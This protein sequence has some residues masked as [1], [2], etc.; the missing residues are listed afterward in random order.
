MLLAYPLDKHYETNL[1]S[2]NADLALFSLDVPHLFLHFIISEKL[3]LCRVGLNDS[4]FVN[5][6]SSDL[7]S[8]QSSYA[9]L[10]EH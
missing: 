1:L 7:H 2:A 6:L 8:N 3:W 5:I 4:D 10:A 9:D